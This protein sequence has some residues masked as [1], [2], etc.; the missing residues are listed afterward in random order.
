MLYEI[1]ADSTTW[2]FAQTIVQEKDSHT[3]VATPPDTPSP[4]T[5]DTDSKVAF[6]S[7]YQRDRHRFTQLLD[8]ISPTAGTGQQKMAA[9][10]GLGWTTVVFCWQQRG[11]TE[12]RFSIRRY[13]YKSVAPRSYRTC[14]SF[15]C[16]SHKWS[17][18]SRIYPYTRIILY[19]CFTQSTGIV[20]CSSC[21][22]PGKNS[23]CPLLSCGNSWITTGYEAAGT[24]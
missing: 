13:W 7:Y 9:R 5:S 16:W 6:L 24:R 21:H 17:N 10:Q 18:T 19:A 2:S 23:W 15:I 12:R 8:T 14:R 3:T 20:G 4:T 11:I 22:R 1:K